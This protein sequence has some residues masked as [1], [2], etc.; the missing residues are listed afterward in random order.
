VSD[1]FLSQLS[2]KA[3]KRPQRGHRLS[4]PT[5]G[6]ATSKQVSTATA[7][8]ERH[9][10][11]SMRAGKYER[12]TIALPPEQKRLIKA[13]AANNQTGMLQFYR[14][15]IDQGLQAYEEGARPEPETA[16][17]KD[18]KMGHWSSRV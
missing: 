8:Q 4:D 7:E 17:Y 3:P 15:L 9:V 12:Q 2:D 16:V 18:V 6:R 5:A 11:K 1:D 10:P 14:W 13:M